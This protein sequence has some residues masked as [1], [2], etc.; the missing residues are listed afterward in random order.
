[1]S[2]PERHRR[3]V[4]ALPVLKGSSIHDA[5][6]GFAPQIEQN[7]PF[8]VVRGSRIGIQFHRFRKLRQGA[9]QVELVRVCNSQIQMCA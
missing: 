3:N 1:M 6:T 5:L 8:V 9:F 2:R 4:I 7:S